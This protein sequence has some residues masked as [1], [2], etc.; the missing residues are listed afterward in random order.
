MITLSYNQESLEYDAYALLTSFYPGIETRQL[1]SEE[2]TGEADELHI[3]AEE[4][5]SCRLFFRAGAV[6]DKDREYAFSPEREATEGAPGEEAL[7]VLKWERK[8]FFYDCFADYSGRELPWGGLTGVRPTK[9][10]LGTARE[11]ELSEEE[12]IRFMYEQYRVSEEKAKL[13]YRIAMLEDG[14]LDPFRSGGYSLYIGIPFCPSTCLYCS[15]LSYPIAAF[16]K[17]VSEYLDC[18]ETELAALPEIMKGQAPDTVYIG[19]GT[20][21]A[22]SA[23]ELERLLEMVRR[24]IPASGKNTQG[25]RFRLQTG[26]LREFTVE[27]GRPDSITPEKLRVMR[28]YV[29]DRISVNPQTFKEETLRLIGRHHTTEQLCEAFALA[30]S[31]GFDNINM[32]LILGLPGEKLSDVEHTLSRVAELGPDSLTVHSLALKRAAKMREWV[33]EHGQ[34]SG[35]DYECAMKM[36]SD[37]ADALGMKPYYLYRQKNMA[38]ALENTG[39]AREGKYGLYNIVIM[40]EVQSIYAIGAGTVSKKVFTDGSGRIERCDTHK[41]LSLYLSD[42]QAMIERK[43]RL[44]GEG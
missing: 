42:I 8:R 29:V 27:A 15:F 44:F 32:D 3:H 19:G 26:S 1:L 43:R 25:L 41:D 12:L 23:E 40:E 28:K 20:P 17:K 18:V 39:F 30:R 22:L 34:I 37:T 35:L 36:A 4:D 16:R 7:R 21:T 33:A 31:E 13:G 10:I 2:G 6:F 5:G 14:L 9:L 24:L 11:R 38:G